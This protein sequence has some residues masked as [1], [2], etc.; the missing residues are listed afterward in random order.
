MKILHLSSEYPPQRVYGLGRF[1]RDLSEEQVRQGHDVTVVTNSMGG[2][3]RDEII[4][5]VRVCRIEFPPPP[6]PSLPSGQILVFNTMILSRVAGLGI[7]QIL[8]YEVINSHDWLT[9][10][11]AQ[12]LHDAFN[13]PHVCTFHDVIVGK[14]LGRLESEQDRFN[15]QTE[16]WVVCHANRLIANSEATKQELVA[17]Y[18]ANPDN[19]N[20]VPCAIAPDTFKTEESE[21]RRWYFRQILADRNSL[22]VLYVGRLD[23]EKGVQI[24]LDAFSKASIPN[25]KLYIAG[26]GKLSDQLLAGIQRLKL[27][28]HVHL[29][30]YVESPVLQNLFHA[31]DI[32]VCPSLY[33][34]FGMVAIEAMLQGTPVIASRTGGLCE[35]IEHEANGILVQPGNADDLA[36][37]L[38]RL[39]NDVSFRRRLGYAARTTVL[40]TRT[41]NLACRKTTEVYSLIRRERRHSKS[42]AKQ[43]FISGYVDGD[44]YSQRIHCQNVLKQIPESFEIINI[45]ENDSPNLRPISIED[46]RL[47]K[48]FKLAAKLV[49]YIENPP[50]EIICCGWETMLACS[51]FDKVRRNLRI[52]FISPHIWVSKE[53]ITRLQYAFNEEFYCWAASRA[54]V[55]HSQ[56]CSTAKLYSMRGIPSSTEFRISNTKQ[57]Q[58]STP[59]LLRECFA[60][61]NE[62]IVFTAARLDNPVSEQIIAKCLGALQELHAPFTWVFAGSGKLQPSIE[63]LALASNRT[64]C[65]LGNIPHELALGILQVCTLTILPFER[66][67]YSSFIS[68]AITAGKAI[69]GPTGLGH[70]LDASSDAVH[71]TNFDDR[72]SIIE[73]IRGIL[74]EFGWQIQQIRT[75][76]PR[77]S[78]S[79]EKRIDNSQKNILLY[80]DWGIGDEVLLSAVAREVARTHPNRQL[81]I[82][83]R[84]GFQFP[85]FCRTGAAPSDAVAV[86]TI[87]QNPVLYGPQHHAPFPGH[88]VQQMLDKVF[89]DTGLL[90]HAEDVRPIFDLKPCIRAKG[91][92]VLHSRPNGRLPSK[93]WGVK[94][95]ER[96][97]ILLDR[98]GAKVIQVGSKNEHLLPHVED[99]RG[100]APCEIPAI[101]ASSSLVICLVGFLMHVAAATKTPAIVIYGGREHPAIDGYEDHFHLS[102]NALD[103]SGRWGCHLG[104]DT[105]V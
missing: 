99:R 78:L 72:R 39:D 8:S 71:E 95:W 55:V 79:P 47:L 30:G 37:A 75:T 33:E 73:C 49:Q 74:K 64:I 88:L 62:I 14:R 96:L 87:Y 59:E 69:I 68:E 19:I 82:R 32:S 67:R 38:I 46:D 98:R 70:V 24:L 18:N 102:T 29:L 66:P 16:Q 12:A 76:L 40:E 34:P 77:L 45:S 17:T 21:I 89:H 92:V 100:V 15:A 31:A 104:P 1:V 84:F 20:V 6:M 10:F 7:S 54:T 50:N 65:C 80:N 60:R 25:S 53:E 43:L 51:V 103:C 42:T 58:L 90:V 81:Y 97:S 48:G 22:M 11:A 94:N 2:L 56:D 27:E 61:S 36:N 44:S 91:T 86:E 26:A 93:D 35:F 85:Q 105:A 83:S 13:I 101:V 28:N 57:P 63:R 52:T 9:S 3:F 5:G 4:N 41:W 23:E